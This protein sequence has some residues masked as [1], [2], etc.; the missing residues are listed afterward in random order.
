MNVLRTVVY[1]LAPIKLGFYLIYHGKK[2]ISAITAA[3]PPRNK[4]PD[5]SGDDCANYCGYELAH[6]G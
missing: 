6:L 4:P 3:L 2:S 5:E 1:A